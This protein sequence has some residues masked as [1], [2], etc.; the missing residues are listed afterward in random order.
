MLILT[1]RIG[2]TVV[3]GDDVTVAVLDVRGSR[4]RVGINAP[5]TVSVYR[6][7]IYPRIKRDQGELPREP[8]QAEQV[9]PGAARR[10]A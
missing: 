2:Q 10:S 6:R 1:R 5:K 7:E 8:T 9:K 4:V 3:I